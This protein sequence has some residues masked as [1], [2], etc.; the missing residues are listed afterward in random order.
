VC[1]NWNLRTTRCEIRNNYM[2][3]QWRLRF[4]WQSLCEY[5][6]K[7]ISKFIKPSTDNNRREVNQKSR[8]NCTPCETSAFDFRNAY[9]RTFTVHWTLFSIVSH[10]L[11]PWSR[12]FRFSII[13]NENIIHFFNFDDMFK[14]FISRFPDP[15]F[16]YLNETSNNLYVR[17]QC[18]HIECVLV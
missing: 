2:V 6:T 5:Q 9:A 18:D 4:R 10:R 8:G 16:I 12:I 7:P 1:D 14:F 3:H 11:N 15:S 17:K 13:K